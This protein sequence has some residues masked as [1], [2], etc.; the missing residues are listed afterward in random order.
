M[1]A[2]SPTWYRTRPHGNHSPHLPTVK[3]LHSFYRSSLHSGEN[4]AVLQQVDLLAES[5]FDVE[6]IYLSSDDL[7]S[8]LSAKALTAVG[9]TIGT[10][11]AR[12]P[13]EW[14]AGADLLHIHNT[15]PTMSHEWLGNAKIPKVLTAH[16][17]RAFCANALFL[18]DGQRCMECTTQG[19]SRAV[20]HGCYRNSRIR[21][22][23]L[24]IQQN[25]SRSLAQLMRRCHQVLV[26]GEPM[27]E[28]F[29][30]LGVS[31]TRLLPQPAPATHNDAHSFPPTNAWLFVGR[32]SNE[33][34]LA[35][36][37]RIWPAQEEIVVIGEGPESTK[38]QE[39]AHQRQLPVQF[40]GG[41]ENREVRSIMSTSRG[42]VFPSR[43]LEGAPLVYGEA[44]Q[45]GLPIVAADG[46]TLATQTLADHTGA[47]FTW[48]DPSSL[49][50]ALGFVAERRAEL[51]DRAQ[52]IYASRYTPDVW[53]DNVT[54]IYRSAISAHQ[55]N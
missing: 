38:A 7:D 29:R 42:L 50:T 25:S 54:E 34:G 8:N 15:F 40:L 49:T 47:V 11:T 51:A 12:P 53:I 10:P 23:P 44:M 26:P 33:K 32:V 21:S 43:A 41:K 39:I 1:R 46:S 52:A 22:I 31:N 35:E 45:S 24:A 5:G 17:Y 3:V 30:S 37:F 2:L 19:S 9:L 28:I 18:R 13:Q 55:S 48:D 16:N 27:Q 20:L 36:L 6:L 14:L 4:E